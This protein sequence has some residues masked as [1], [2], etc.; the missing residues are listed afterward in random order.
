MFFFLLLFFFCKVGDKRDF[1]PWSRWSACSQYCGSGGLRYRVRS[2]IRDGDCQGQT[3]QMSTCYKTKC[4]GKFWFI[5][6]I[7]ALVDL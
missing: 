6:I 1:G 2:C 3:L 7:E 5:A 4:Y